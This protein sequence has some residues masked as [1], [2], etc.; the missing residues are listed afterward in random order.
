MFSHLVESDFHT[1]DLKR[2]GTFFMMTLAAYAVVFGLAGVAGV[3]AYEAHIDDHQ[4]LEL[5]A[6][7]PPETEAPRP[8]SVQPRVRP[9]TTQPNTGGASQPRGGLIKN[10]PP[11][12]IST[13]LTKTSG[14]AKASTSQPPP[15]FSDGTNRPFDPGKNN[16]FGTRG[17]DSGDN[18][19]GTNGNGTG[20]KVLNDDAPVIAKK[21]E[22]K[23]NQVVSLGVVNGRAL[24]LPQPTYPP[25][26]KAANIEGVV[27]VEILIDETGRVASARATNGNPLLRQ[28]AER[29][30]LRARFSP[31]LLSEQPV[32]A[33]GVITFNFILR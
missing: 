24:S 27:A 23:K 32:K 13:D 31:T 3:Y 14:E 9:V 12:N 5:V 15:I 25:V 10:T 30:A 18:S 20:D 8:R 1:R 6:L 16:P 4:T 29:A 11:E 22:K 26:A 7:V 33:K 21:P 19:V 17:S 28:E 2:K